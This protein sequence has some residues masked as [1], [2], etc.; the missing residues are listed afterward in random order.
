MTLRILDRAPR[1]FGDLKKVSLIKT[2]NLQQTRTFEAT[3]RALFNAFIGF[4]NS[5]SVLLML[6]VSKQTPFISSAVFNVEDEVLL[7]GRKR[8]TTV[9]LNLDGLDGCER[10]SVWC[11]SSIFKLVN[12]SSQQYHSGPMNKSVRI[13]GCVV[14]VIRIWTISNTHGFSY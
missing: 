2:V 4:L 1:F 3:A 9:V 6:K 12:G 14:Y 11:S 7:T 13:Y 5:F 8:L 10:K